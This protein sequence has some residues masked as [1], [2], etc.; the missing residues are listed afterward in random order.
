MIRSVSRLPAGAFPTVTVAQLPA[1]EATPGRIFIVSDAA[2][3]LD[4]NTAVVGGGF[5]TVAVI[6]Y[7][8][9]WLPLHA[10]SGFTPANLSSVDMLY[11]YEINDL[12]TLFQDAV[13]NIPAVE[14][15]VVGLIR[16][17]SGND[18]HISILANVQRPVLRLEDGNYWLEWD[19]IDD[20]G[21]VSIP[22]LAFPM[23]R[24]SRIRQMAW[25][26]AAFIYAA[27]NGAC[28]GLQQSGTVPNFRMNSGGANGPNTVNGSV[29]M[30]AAIALQQNCVVS[31]KAI[32]ANAS[33]LTINRLPALTGT[34][35]G[36]DVPN[37]FHISRTTPSAV[38]MGTIVCT[39]GIPSASELALLESYIANQAGV[40]L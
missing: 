1:S 4:I 17:K 3:P 35:M 9:G 28:F 20:D 25:Q 16:D 13:G 40:T 32:T 7:G 18:N 38:M 37:G 29:D 11:W 5:I 8:Y 39:N 27:P 31:E 30:P 24:I 21:G 10:V 12:T 26:S 19:G 33:R 23:Y 36:L 2:T 14:G 15:S 22:D 34:N 6:S